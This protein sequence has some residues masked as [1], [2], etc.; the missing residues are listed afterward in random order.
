MSLKS[1][2]EH[3]Q[4]ITSGHPSQAVSGAVYAHNIVYM[5]EMPFIKKKKHHIRSF[6]MDLIVIIVLAMRL[7]YFIIVYFENNKEK[8]IPQTLNI[9]LSKHQ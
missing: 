6:T 3:Y 9:S 7:N 2:N 4:N 5:N 1:P 8:I